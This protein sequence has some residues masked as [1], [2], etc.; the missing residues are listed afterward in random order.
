MYYKLNNTTYFNSKIIKTAKLIEQIITVVM[1]KI[2]SQVLNDY[3]RA[4]SLM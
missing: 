4:K 2:S 3:F 1:T